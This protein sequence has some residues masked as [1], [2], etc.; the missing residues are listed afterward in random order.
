MLVQLRLTV[1]QKGIFLPFPDPR[2]LFKAETEPIAHL[3]AQ[4]GT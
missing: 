3:Q 1:T 4:S 2:A